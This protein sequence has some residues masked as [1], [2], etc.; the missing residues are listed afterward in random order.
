MIAS[1]PGRETCVKCQV[2]AA[3][4]IGTVYRTFSRQRSARLMY[5]DVWRQSR[6]DIDVPSNAVVTTTI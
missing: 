2:G 3:S 4:R 6:V 1:L 5:F